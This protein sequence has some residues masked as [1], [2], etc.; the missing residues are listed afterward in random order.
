MGSASE[1]TA[2]LTTWSALAAVTLGLGFWLAWRQASAQ[3]GKVNRARGRLTM[4]SAM[5]A[6]TASTSRVFL[7]DKYAVQLPG[8]WAQ[9]AQLEAGQLV[10][11]EL[12]VDDHSI[13]RYQHA[14]SIDDEV[15]RLPLVRWGRP[16]T[17]ALCGALVIGGVAIW[18]DD[19]GGDA[20]QARALFKRGGERRVAEPA[21]L[22]AKPV[23]VGDMVR[24]EATARCDWDHA[25]SGL[26]PI[27]CHH[28]RWGAPAVT[29]GDLPIEPGLQAFYDGSFVQSRTDLGLNAMLQMQLTRSALLEGGSQS[30]YT[31]QMLLG[32]T[33]PSVVRV[34]KVDELIGQVQAACGKDVVRNT[35]LSTTCESLQTGIAQNLKLDA[36]PDDNARWSDLLTLKNAGKLAESVGANVGV[37]RSSDVSEWRA[38]AREVASQQLAGIGGELLQKATQAQGAGERSVQVVLTLA[39]ATSAAAKLQPSA[40]TGDSVPDGPVALWAAY[41]QLLGPDGAQPRVAAGLVTRSQRNAHGDWEV[42]IDASRRLD[43]AGP[44][45][46]RLAITLLGAYLL[47]VHGTLFV[48]NARRAYHRSKAVAAYCRER[49]PKPL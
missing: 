20:A 44:A 5:L 14:L 10:D 39:R 35:E 47:L 41:Q 43:N 17:L 4:A 16:L 30:P 29:L 27:D 34:S 6:N 33:L 2:G 40:P 15:R 11:L 36:L 38:S 49:A 19:A 25:V 45:L 21:D 7:G 3:P 42:S 28:L 37:A 32:A 46:M 12:R 9:H 18:H 31:S 13:V 23:Q 24:V 48:V 26:P 8:H 1:S 22:I